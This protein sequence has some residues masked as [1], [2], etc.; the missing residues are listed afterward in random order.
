MAT[1]AIENKRRHVFTRVKDLLKADQMA[2]VD[3][4]KITD[5]ELRYESLNELVDKF[6]SL[7]MEMV[8][9]VDPENL[10]IQDDIQRDLDNVQY[11]IRGIYSELFPPGN[12]SPVGSDRGS[13]RSIASTQVSQNHNTDSCFKVKLP[14]IE[15]PKFN[16]D[17]ND[18]P[19]F[20]DTY[21]RLI[22]E[23]VT[24]SD[25]ERFQYLLSYLSVEPLTIVRKLPTTGDNYLISFQSLE[26]RYQ[27]KWVLLTRY[28]QGIFN[29][30]PFN[31][32]AASSLRN[33]L[34]AFAENL[35]AIEKFII[36]M[37]DFTK[38]N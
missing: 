23:N 37:W 10:K 33:V 31:G 3:S 29:V 4:N 32:N 7:Q 21:K 25:I 36:D 34:S 1:K 6:E 28:W 26:K 19:T 11:S 14:K 17:M 9:V 5:F 35:A 24:L 8:S 22:H 12:R 18:W 13:V 16:G 2:L 30:E 20:Y 27:D 38:L 15:V